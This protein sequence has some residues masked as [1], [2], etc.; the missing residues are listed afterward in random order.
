MPEPKS[1]ATIVALADLADFSADQLENGHSV[2][3]VIALLRRAAIAVRETVDLPPEE[4]ELVAAFEPVVISNTDEI[5]ETTASI[6][7]GEEMAE[8]ATKEAEPVSA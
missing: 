3:N 8:E 2:E 1:T 7:D 4:A 6:E 5:E